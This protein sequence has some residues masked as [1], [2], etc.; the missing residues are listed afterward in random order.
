MIEI[1]VVKGVV[2]M[3]YTVKPGDTL[4][5]ISQ[6]F[7]TPMEKIIS[8]NQLSSPNQL[9]I[10]EALIINNETVHTVQPGETLYHIAS[11]YGISLESLIRSN[12]YLTDFDMISPGQSLYLAPPKLGSLI[13][14]GYA[15]PNINVGVVESTLPFLTYLSIFSYEV[16]PDGSLTALNDQPMI[17]AA[18]KQKVAPKMVLTN[19]DEEGRF[20]SELASSI[21]NN[22][23]VQDT[24]LENTLAIMK[25]KG[26]LG[27]DVDFEYLFPADREAYNNFL[28]KAAQMMHDNG[29]ILST[30]VAP[31]ISAD[32]QGTLYEAHDYEAQGKILDHI[33]LMTY[34]WGYAYGPPRAIAPID[35]VIKVLDY[36]ITEIPSKK[37]LLGIP[38]YGY[39]WTLP[40][41]PG[42]AAKVVRHPEAIELARSTGAIIEYDETSQ[43]PY[44]FYY[45]AQGKQ[46]VV[47]FEDARSIYEKL[48]LVEEYNLGGVSYWNVNSP[49]PINW[50]ILSSMYEIQK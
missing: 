50:K 45:D 18:Y 26:Y 37:I 30:A 11:R 42:T 10:G 36:A 24:L 8:D 9:T 34:D 40:Y 22:P 12:P 25:E 38:N 39:D 16:R 20:S 47:W 49:F 15:Y 6:K 35:E 33:I 44:F 31:K 41:T 3:I 2:A 23:Q 19:L 27:L 13:A 4:Y 32:Q 29:Y 7:H 48:M 14:N 1:N 46:H 28:R 17:D 5:R 21:L 43:A